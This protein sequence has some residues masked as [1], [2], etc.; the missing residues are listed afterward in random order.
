MVDF[1]RRHLDPGSR[2][3]EVLFAL[4]MALGFTGSVRLGLEDPD[5][6][7]LFAGILGCNL[8]WAIVDAAMY[9]L[10]QVFERGRTARLVREVRQARSDQEAL[11]RI[12]TELDDRLPVVHDAPGAEQFHRWLLDLLRTG[13]LRVPQLTANDGK[14]ALAVMLLIVFS[15]LPMLVPFLVLGD[16]W[17]AARASNFVALAMLFVLGAWWG[18]EV[19][20]SPWSIGAG[21]TAIGVALV[22]VTI[23]LGG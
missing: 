15:T 8:A 7:E 14:A 17:T 9:L 23:A 6:R 18:R 10:L 21:L 16:P 19:G 12:A 22:L 1:I 2:L 11:A 13:D 3:G 4:I 5:S 20:R